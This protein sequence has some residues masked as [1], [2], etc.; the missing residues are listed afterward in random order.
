MPSLL[1]QMAYDRWA[2]I[3]R[4]P[5]LDHAHRGA[6]RS[7]RHGQNGFGWSVGREDLRKPEP[8]PTNFRHLPA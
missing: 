1:D 6:P 8:L 2:I 4:G 3:V 5:K 7:R